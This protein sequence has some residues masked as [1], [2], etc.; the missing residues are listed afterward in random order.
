[1]GISGVLGDIGMTSAVH[2]LLRGQRCYPVIMGG[3]I[4]PV[5]ERVLWGRGE[6]LYIVSSGRGLGAR[7]RHDQDYVWR[8]M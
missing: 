5:R 6:G 7:I 1:M 4:G 8:A 3:L 2:F